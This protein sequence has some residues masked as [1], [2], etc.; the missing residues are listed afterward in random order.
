MTHQSSA[1]YPLHTD[2]R[3]GEWFDPETLLTPLQKAANP[4]HGH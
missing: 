3:H 1:S 2:F 4:A